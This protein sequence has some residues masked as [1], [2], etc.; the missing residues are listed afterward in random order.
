MVFGGVDATYR[1]TLGSTTED[2]RSTI[3]IHVNRR[4][5]RQ[6]SLAELASALDAFSKRMAARL[7]LIAMGPC[8]NDD[9][10]ARELRALMKSSPIIIDQPPSLLTVAAAISRSAQYVGCSLHGFITA[11]A[12]GIPARI[13]A[14]HSMRKFP[15]LLSSIGQLNL[16][17]EDWNSALDAATK[18]DAARETRQLAKIS[19]RF[20]KELDAHWKRI[21]DVINTRHSI[22][23]SFAPPAF[24]SKLLELAADKNDAAFLRKRLDSATSQISVLTDLI[25]SERCEREKAHVAAA[26]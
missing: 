8:H 12:F 3:A 25:D 15:E 4:Y 20:T 17:H 26:N 9:A 19:S 23:K 24:R 22:M 6:T 5:L 13:V 16:L 1:A 11:A 18:V 2:A 7:I 14:A 21:Y 10:I